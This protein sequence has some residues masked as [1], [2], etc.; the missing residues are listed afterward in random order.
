MAQNCNSSA[1]QVAR[2]AERW[3]GD[4]CCHPMFF[5]TVYNWHLWMWEFEQ[6][7]YPHIPGHLKT[8]S[9]SMVL[10]GWFEEVWHGKQDSQFSMQAPIPCCGQHVAECC[11]VS[12]LHF[13]SGNR[14]PPK[15]TAFYSLPWLWCFYHNNRNVTNT[16]G[17]LISTPR[18]VSVSRDIL[19]KD[20]VIAHVTEALVCKEWSTFCFTS[21]CFI[22]ARTCTGLHFKPHSHRYFKCIYS[23]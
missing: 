5:T 23:F 16:L 2:F 6:A 22:Q 12:L 14:S 21:F 19:L 4:R 18:L 3:S 13:P 15:T 10:S 1:A 17:F 7:V 8:W 11:H 20:T 9:Q